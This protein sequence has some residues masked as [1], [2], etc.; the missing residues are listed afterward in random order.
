MV[1]FSVAMQ[2]KAKLAH[3]RNRNVPVCCLDI[4]YYKELSLYM[5]RIALHFFLLHLPQVLKAYLI[6]FIK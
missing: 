4:I 2:P 1:R 3:S 5:L 6:L